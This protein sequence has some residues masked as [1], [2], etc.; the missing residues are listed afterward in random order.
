M[1]VYVCFVILINLIPFDVIN[2]EIMNGFS[3]ML[4]KWFLLVNVQ[5]TSQ[6]VQ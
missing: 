3:M 2:L 5:M 4:V 1:C 6:T